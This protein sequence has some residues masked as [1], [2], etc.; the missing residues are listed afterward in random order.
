[1][2]ERL[3]RRHYDEMR[4]IIREDEPPRPSNRISTL[5]DTIL[6]W[7][8]IDDSIRSNLAMRSAASSTGL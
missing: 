6:R 1:M 3:R 8:R 4:R 5:G 2:P 7:R